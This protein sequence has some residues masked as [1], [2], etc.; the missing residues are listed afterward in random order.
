MNKLNSLTINTF[1]IALT[2]SALSCNSKPFRT[3]FIPA[4]HSDWLVTP[5]KTP[6]RVIERPERNEVIITNGLISRTFRTSP[7]AATVA[8]DNLIT[9]QSILRGVKPEAVLEINGKKYEV[10]GLKGQPNYAYLTDEWLDSLTADPAAFQFVDYKIGKTKPPF[11]WKQKRHSQNSPWP[12]PGASLILNFKLLPEKLDSETKCLKDLTVSIHYEMYDRLP[13]IA[14]WFTLKNASTEP[15]KLNSF[16]SEILAVVE[17]ESAVDNRSRW[18]YPNIHVESDYAFHGMDATT[19]NEVIHWQNDPEYLTQVSYARTN[20]C[21]L[22]AKLKLGPDSI[23]KPSE[24]FESFRVFELIYDSTERERQGLSLRRMYRT[25]APWVTENPL[26][27]H[28]R[29]ADWD[30]VKNAI[31][32]CAEVGFEMVILTFGSGFNIE[33][34]ST[35][36]LAEM[37]KYADYAK[38]RGVEIGG[39]SLL[40]SRR[41]S[42][43]DDVIN[44][45]T[46]K[47]GGF[48]TFGN[49]PCLASKWAIDYFK[50]LYTFFPKTGFNLLEHDGSYPGDFCASQKHPGHTGYADSQYKQWKVISDFYKFCREEGIYLNV[51][52]FYYLTGSNKC[53]MGYRETNWSLPRPQ[54]VIHTR[55]NIYDG[56][57]QKTPSMGWMFVPL[58]EYHGGG[59]AA[60][61]EPLNEHLDH[62]ELMLMSNLGAGVQAC[63]RGPR[64]Y[65]SDQTKKMVKKCVDWYKRHREVLEGDLVHLRRADGRDI[66][67]W[68][69][70]NPAANEKGLLMVY[71]PLKREV[72]KTIRVPLYYTGLTDIATISHR[73][74]KSN[75]FKL[76]KNCCV[77][78]PVQ[79]KPNSY[80][81]FVIR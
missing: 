66:D 38:S 22:E 31:D 76:D 18:L 34:D 52:D 4:L 7:N 14:K 49:S 62:Y 23:V 28:V 69:N 56:T 35:E 44:P 43:E 17:A 55:Q 61:I 64:L 29:Y 25:I 63:Y 48:A 6:A 27:M 37:K 46:G 72:K 21:L 36:Y 30:T 45:Q 60:T 16:L 65:D 15:I 1:L 74:E 47:P 5:V 39:Y 8:F 2:F 50:K 24:A 12:T 54:Q 58:T 19:A 79:V 67:Y 51:P 57:W 26:M 3:Y 41:V 70:V 42:D 53:G 9:G 80:T 13:V 73:D 33:N 32:Q 10:G 59:A 11:P 71:N 40:A 81:W 68:L 78:L 77:M 75:A 20:P